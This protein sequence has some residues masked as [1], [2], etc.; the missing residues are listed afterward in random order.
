MLRTESSIDNRL[1]I[2]HTA[3]IGLLVPNQKERV[4]TKYV[5]S[6]YETDRGS[7]GTHLHVQFFVYHEVDKGTSLSGGDH[8]S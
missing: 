4:D 7:Q 8:D 2:S 5:K 1:N 3:I 6:L